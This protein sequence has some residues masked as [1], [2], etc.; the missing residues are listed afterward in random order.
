M[1][2]SKHH[3]KHVVG[4]LDC[5]PL[6]SQPSAWHFCGE[7]PLAFLIQDA[8]VAVNILCLF[9]NK[10]WSRVLLCCLPGEAVMLWPSVTKGDSITAACL[11]LGMKLAFIPETFQGFFVVCRDQAGHR[12][13]LPRLA[14][15]SCCSHRTARIRWAPVRKL[16]VV[17]IFFPPLL[18]FLLFPRSTAVLALMRS[19]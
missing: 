5:L 6:L 12:C 15:H 7:T 11:C 8:I 18:S 14:V 19:W 9:L 3:S 1:W 10:L 16:H 13:P 2:E 17:H 4:H